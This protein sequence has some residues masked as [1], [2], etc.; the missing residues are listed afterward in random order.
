M[1]YL[2]LP[3]DLLEDRLAALPMLFVIERTDPNGDLDGYHLVLPHVEI[4]KGTGSG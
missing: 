4:K 2:R 3:L 1:T